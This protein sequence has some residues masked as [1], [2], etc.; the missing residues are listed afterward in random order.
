MA[1]VREECLAVQGWGRHCWLLLI[2]CKHEY[3][4]TGNVARWCRPKDEWERSM[5]MAEERIS[6]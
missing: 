2:D 5:P 4:D 6:R 1:D 3:Y